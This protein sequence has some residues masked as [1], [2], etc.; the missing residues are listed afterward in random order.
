M[1]HHDKIV[2]QTQG[3]EQKKRDG[4]DGYFEAKNWEGH[5][6]ISTVCVDECSSLLDR[7]TNSASFYS[8]NNCTVKMTA[9]FIESCRGSVEDVEGFAKSQS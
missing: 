3:I 2:R 4:I 7:Y 1:Q 8:V 6:Q 9:D 5:V